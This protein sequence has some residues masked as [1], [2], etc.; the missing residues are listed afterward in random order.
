MTEVINRLY[1]KV[2][3]K[4]SNFKLFPLSIRLWLSAKGLQILL[5]TDKWED[6]S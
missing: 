3:M 4:L 6:Y 5:N 2:V 1:F